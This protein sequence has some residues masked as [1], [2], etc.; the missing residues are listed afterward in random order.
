MPASLF[1]SYCM[2]PG[3]FSV[4]HGNQGSVSIVFETTAS[5]F[6]AKLMPFFVDVECNA[7]H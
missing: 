6:L 2:W 3:L 4:L 5:F 1:V 7:G